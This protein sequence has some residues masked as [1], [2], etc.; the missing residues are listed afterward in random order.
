MA[1][2]PEGQRQEADRDVQAVGEGLDLAGPAVGPE[3][4]EDLDRVAARRAPAASGR[5]TRRVSVTQSRP[6][7]SKARLSGLWMSGSAATSWISNPGGHVQRLAFVLGRARR[8]RRDV[9]DRRRG[10][11]PD[12]RRDG[13]GRGTTGA[14]RSRRR[15]TRRMTSLLV[16][17]RPPSSRRII[18]NGRRTRRPAPGRSRRRTA[19]CSLPGP[20]TGSRDSPRRGSRPARRP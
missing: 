12:W 10:L 18:M 11:R 16:L 6:R 19:G 9:L 8:Q 3:V 20:G 13:P 15:A 7:S 4:G 5:D 14:P 1:S 2:R 17:N